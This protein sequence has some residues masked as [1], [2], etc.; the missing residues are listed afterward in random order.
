MLFAVDRGTAHQLRDE[1]PAMLLLLCIVPR[2]ITQDPSRRALWTALREHP[3]WHVPAGKPSSHRFE[4]LW[5]RALL[6]QTA[7][8]AGSI[9]ALH[10]L[11]GEILVAL[12]RLP[13]RPARSDTAARRIQIVAQELGESF[14]DEW[15]LDRAADRAGLSR[16]R[17]SELFRAHTGATFL[18]TLTALRLSHAA[19]L[20]RQGSH[21]VTGVAF[22][23]GYRDLSHFYR[24]FRKRHGCSPGAFPADS[25]KR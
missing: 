6:E 1:S 22:S 24:V 5:R 19:N 13:A 18:D 14:Y 12:A 20:L 9:V 21:S 16:R 2:F 25:L 15:T 4:N 11:A 3:T 8:R 17:F 7:S 10:A 23:C